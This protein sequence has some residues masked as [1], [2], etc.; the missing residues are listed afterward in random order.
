MEELENELLDTQNQDVE[1]AIEN[2]EVQAEEVKNG[3]KYN[4]SYN[5]LYKT[6]KHYQDGYKKLQKVVKELENNSV[7]TDI[8]SE[9]KSEVDNDETLIISLRQDNPLLSREDAAEI[10]KTIKK[11][12]VVNGTST[13]EAINDDY[14]K[15]LISNKISKQ[16]DYQATPK[17][18]HVAG[19]S[20]NDKIDTKALFDKYSK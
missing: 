19:I 7:K 3:E 2:P 14:V 10:S 20:N 13:Y 16:Q 8:Q 17:S 4:K 18:S 6:M 15:S 9:Q 5:E 11:I 12:A 1:N